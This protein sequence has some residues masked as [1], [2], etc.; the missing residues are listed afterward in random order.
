VVGL[1]PSPLFWYNEVKEN[2]ME[3]DF[4]NKAKIISEFSLSFLVNDV[5]FDKVNRFYNP[6]VYSLAT[7]L[8]GGSV[9]ALEP[10]VKNIDRAW[11]DFLEVFDVEDKGFTCMAEVCLEAG[12]EWLEYV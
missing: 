10:A 11:I 8:D 9:V 7:L 1:A 12:G 4:M 6:I 5:R 2:T 3:T